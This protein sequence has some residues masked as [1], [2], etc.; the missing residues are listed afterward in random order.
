M[1]RSIVSLSSARNMQ[2][3]YITDQAVIS[4]TLKG[5][6]S[7][8]LFC[9][10][11]PVLSAQ[12]TSTPAIPQSL[13]IC[14]QSPFFLQAVAHRQPLSPIILL[15]SPQVLQQRSTPR[16]I[17]KWSVSYVARNIATVIIQ[18]PGPQLELSGNCLF[19]RSAF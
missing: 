14:L 5:S 11:V 4:L 10:R 13:P 18:P 2:C 16:Q 6:P 12:S 15:A 7:V 9:V 19:L 17:A 1:A 3:D 8:S